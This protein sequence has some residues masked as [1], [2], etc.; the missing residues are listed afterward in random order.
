MERGSRSCSFGDGGP[1]GNDPTLA[2]AH[3]VFPPTAGFDAP[4]KALCHCV[5]N[6]RCC[7]PPFTA[8]ETGQSERVCT[9]EGKD[10]FE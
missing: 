2:C 10:Q 7:K 5:S 6:G 9:T 8:E 4:F 3:P 1:S